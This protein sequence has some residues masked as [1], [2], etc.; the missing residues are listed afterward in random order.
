[1]TASTPEWDLEIYLNPE[2]KSWMLV[3]KAKNSNDSRQL[4]DLAVGTE[5]YTKQKW[6]QEYFNK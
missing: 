4:C 5:D 2:S 1:M 6:Y 3:G